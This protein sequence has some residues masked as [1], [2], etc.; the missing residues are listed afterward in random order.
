MCKEQLLTR[1]SVREENAT[2]SNIYSHAQVGR[3]EKQ[4]IEEWSGESL[5]HGE[6]MRVVV[7]LFKVDR[8]DFEKFKSKYF[9]NGANQIGGWERQEG[10]E[11][12]PSTMEE[13]PSVK[14]NRD[15]LPKTMDKAP[16]EGNKTSQKENRRRGNSIAMG[17]K[18]LGCLQGERSIWFWFWLGLNL[19]YTF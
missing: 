16:K 14:L 4:L 17:I 13:K 18:L 5:D 11:S 8:S 7:E 3:T 12:G 1:T 19:I 15:D 2:T 9:K 6:M 10:A